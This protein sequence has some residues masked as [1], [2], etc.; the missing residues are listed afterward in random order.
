M[1]NNWFAWHP[2]AFGPH[3]AWFSTIQRRYNNDQNCWYYRRL[4]TVDCT[5]SRIHKGK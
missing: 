4:P 5:V 3:I 2:V 1:W